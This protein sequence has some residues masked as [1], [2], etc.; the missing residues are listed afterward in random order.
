MSDAA[1]FEFECEA[2]QDY[3]PVKITE[4]DMIS[5]LVQRYN[6]IAMGAHRYVVADHVADKTGWAARIADFIA[7][8]CYGHGGYGPNRQHSIHGHEV[9]VSRSDWLT[10]LRDPEKA[11]GIPALRASLVARGSECV[12]R[13][14]RRTTRRLGPDGASWWQPAGGRSRTTA[15]TGAD[16]VAD[17]RVPVA[18]GRE[19]GPTPG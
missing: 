10:E 17:E 2:G 13:A 3:R 8:D 6:K 15:D 5:L 14:R 19:D 4:R 12:D 1:L 16:A 11:G 7:V 9:K 18:C